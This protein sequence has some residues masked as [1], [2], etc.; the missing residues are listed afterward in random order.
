MSPALTSRELNRATLARQLLLERAHCS[1]ADAVEHLVGMQAQAPRAPFVGLWSRLAGFRH[2]ELSGLVTSRA[3]VRVALQRRTLHL[4]SA[5]DCLAMRPLLQPVMERGYWA[6]P[7]ARRLAGLDVDAVVRAGQELLDEH[8]LTRVELGRAL[9]RQW[10]NADA[11]ALAYTTS[12]LVPLVQLPPRGTWAGAGAA[13][14][15][16]VRAWLG[17][18]AARPMSAD[19]LLVRYLGAFGP[20]TVMDAQAWC[21]LTRLAEVAERLGG[22]LRHFR[23]EDGRELLDLP[24]APRPEPDTPAP[25]RF[26]PEY[27]NLLLSHADRSRVVPNGRT[28]PL[29]P[30]NGG[31]RGE[32]LVDGTWIADWAITRADGAATLRIEPFV[33]LTQRAAVRA[34]GVRLLA[35]VAPG[36]THDVDITA[37]P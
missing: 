34:E 12:S 26:L 20:A 15:T 1:C 23:D 22:R 28:V 18:E 14:W 5:R 17:A 27:D 30:G 10:P 37:A 19:E 25:P 11:E 9:T 4:V 24:D 29:Y 16:T 32:L 3:A 33:R 6:S 13:R 2:E 35:F 8:P 21:G 7:F 36:A 31:T